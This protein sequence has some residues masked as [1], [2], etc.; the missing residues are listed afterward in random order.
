MT[1]APSIISL[2]KIKDI[3]LIALWGALMAAGAWI[4]LPIGPVPI[5]LQTFF[6]ILA[7]FSLGAKAFFAAALYVLAGILGL[8]VFVGGMAGPAV[9]LGP[10]CGFVLAFPF[11]AIVA[12]LA[13]SKGPK[14]S[15][16]GRLVLFGILAT[17]FIY[18]GGAIGMK[19]NLGITYKASVLMLLTFVPGDSL[20]ILVATL[21]ARSLER[22]FSQ[23]GQVG[24]V[25]LGKDSKSSL[26]GPDSAGGQG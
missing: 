7:G 25:L 11:A 21:V 9:L 23:S 26:D 1:R 20:K 19:I 8:P 18:L 2:Q 16:A 15:S 17:L 24:T 3:S 5:S 22:H 14:V 13:K 6:I 10:T 4:A 12:G